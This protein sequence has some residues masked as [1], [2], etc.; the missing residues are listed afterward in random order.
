MQ[1]II[2][3]VGID[4]AASLARVRLET[5]RTSYSGLIPDAAIAA[6]DMAKETSRWAERLRAP[7]LNSYLFV[8]EIKP[9]MGVDGSEI[10]RVAAGFCG[11]GPERDDDPDYSGELYAIY[12]LQVYQGLGMGRALV[13]R[14]VDWLRQ[15][16]HN[17]ML[18]WVLRDNHNARRFY[19][20][21][22]GKAVRER[23]ITIGGAQLPEVGYGY[24]LSRW[25]GG[26]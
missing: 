9:D 16:G 19:E 10:G 25:P 5:W 7:Q 14:A 6:M 12:V 21:L 22:G 2:R 13:Q 24:D 17:S 20:A 23:S 3:P 1:F 18:I 4:D 26:H 8:A 11:G 15:N